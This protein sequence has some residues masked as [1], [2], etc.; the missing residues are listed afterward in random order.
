MFAPLLCRARRDSVSLSP[1]LSLAGTEYGLSPIP[2]QRA[3][4]YF[5]LLG[6]SLGFTYTNCTGDIPWIWTTVSPLAIA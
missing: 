1:A 5:F 2:V 6:S 4:P 3:S